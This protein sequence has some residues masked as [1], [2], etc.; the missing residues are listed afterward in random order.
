MSDPARRHRAV[1]ALDA[2]VLVDAHLAMLAVHYAS[3]VVAGPGRARYVFSDRIPDVTMNFAVGLEAGDIGWLEHIAR[4]HGRA[5][6]FLS[7]SHAARDWLDGATAYTAC[8]MVADVAAAAGEMENLEDMGLSFRL[9]EGPAPDAAFLEVFGACH[10]G[11]P[12]D[13]HVGQYYVPALAAGRPA[14]GIGTFNAVVSDGGEP[15]AC[16]T[17]YVAGTLA[18]LY[19]VGT[20]YTRQRGGLGLMIVRRILREASRLGAAQVFLQCAAGTHLER[21]YGRAGFHPAYAPVLVCRET[22]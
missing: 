6:A 17:L 13:A 8:W 2:D 15:V 7:F 18:G 3:G 11:G 22:R 14:A 20:R 19:N 10:D 16:A 12:I 4:E 21:L 5:P 9:T 1:E